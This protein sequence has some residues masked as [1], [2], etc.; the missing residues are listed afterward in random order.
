MLARLQALS[1]DALR[2]QPRRDHLGPCRHSGALRRAAEADHRHRLQRGRARRVAARS[3]PRPARVRPPGL[4]VIGGRWCS[5]TTEIIHDQAQR[6]PA[7][8]PQ[9]RRAAR[10]R[11]RP[12]AARDPQ[13]QGRR[14]RQGP[15][16][17]QDQGPDRSPRH[18]ARR[19]PAAAPDHPRR[20]RGH[21]RRAR[22]RR[23]RG[24]DA[25]RHGR[26]VSRCRQSRLS[27]PRP[28]D[29]SRQCSHAGE[30]QEGQGEAQ[31]QAGQP[32]PAE[33]PRRA[34]APSRPR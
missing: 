11:C 8:D 6:H 19:R 26:D 21:R 30:G 17:P 27:M 7:R 10:R 28:G 3:P 18:A 20:P 29:R 13:A 5:P 4:G 31:A 22:G 25:G 1:D 32:E 34:P 23:A 33:S 12:A 2:L 9:R 14:R 16:Q 24:R 15:R